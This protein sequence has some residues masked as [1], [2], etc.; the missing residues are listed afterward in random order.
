MPELQIYT[1]L[2][3]CKDIRY[4]MLASEVKTFGKMCY[5]QKHSFVMWQ[6]HQHQKYY[7]LRHLAKCVSI[8][9]LTCKGIWQMLW[10]QKSYV[11]TRL[12]NLLELEEKWT[13]TFL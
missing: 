10:Y 6:M 12:P 3:I 8:K 2:D 4:N 13:I 1:R 5:H 9:S 11:L 7:L